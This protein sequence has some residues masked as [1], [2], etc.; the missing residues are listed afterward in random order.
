MWCF[1]EELP[2]A[3]HNAVVGYGLPKEIAAKAFVV[4]LR[5][6]SLHPRIL[7]RYDLTQTTLEEEG[8]ESATVD[9][10]GKSPLA[11]MMSATLFGDWVSLYLAI[12]NDVAPAPTPPIGRLKERLARR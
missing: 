7:L 11:Q 2:E 8:V 10:E 6:P 9:A 4:F 1:Y 5:T 3:D 12:L